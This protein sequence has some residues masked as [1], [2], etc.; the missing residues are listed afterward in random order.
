M[1]CG[2]PR[3]GLGWPGMDDDPYSP[4]RSG[5][6]PDPRLF[7][8]QALV[9]IVRGWEKLRIAYNLIL[10]VPGLGIGA[11]WMT[12]Q[13]LPVAF[14]IIQVVLLA[15]GANFAFLLGPAAELYFRALFSRGEPIGVGRIL[16]FGAGLVVSA[17]VLLAAFLLGFL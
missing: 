17:G 7:G 2:R 9:E 11:L 10:L 4:P 16:I 8:K 6:E 12:R 1:G 14:V 3:S 13:Q 5:G 15:L